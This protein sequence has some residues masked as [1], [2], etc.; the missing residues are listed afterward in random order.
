[1]KQILHS[2]FRTI[3]LTLLTLAAATGLK[4]QEKEYLYE[5]GGGLG[6]SWGWND[7]NSSSPIYKPS[8]SFGAVWRYNLNLRWALATEIQSLGLRGDTDDFSYAFPTGSYH[9]STRYWQV[10]LRPEIHFWNYGWGSDYRDK[11]RYTPF[12]T[13]GIAGGMVTGGNEAHFAWGIPLGAGFKWKMNK[14]WNVQLSGIVTKAFSDE[15]DG[16]VD[17]EGIRTSGLAGNDW[18]AQIQ[19]TVTFDFKERCIECHNQHYYGK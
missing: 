18:T 12:L 16:I 9:Y 19:M 11:R 14:R 4:A 15:L 17:P 13:L 1:M 3:L 8:A 2:T 10:G 6:M 7:V 5:I